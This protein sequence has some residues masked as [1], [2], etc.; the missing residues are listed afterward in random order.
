MVQAPQRPIQPSQQQPMQPVPR[1]PVQQNH[2]PTGAPRF[3][4]QPPQNMAPQAAPAAPM[5]RAP[6][7]AGAVPAPFHGNMRH[8]V[9]QDARVWQGGRWHH[10]R[11]GGRDGWWWVVGGLWYFYPQPV[12]PYPDPFIPGE[13]IYTYG[14]SASGSYWYYCASAGQYYPYV[15]YCPEGWQPVIPSDSDDFQDSD[16]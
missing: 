12:Y 4:H 14:P 16:D 10:D 6:R 13:I 9:D 7:A 5:N 3:S 2:G 11:H 1:M 8:F 15:T